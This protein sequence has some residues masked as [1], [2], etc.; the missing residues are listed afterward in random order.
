MIYARSSLNAI[1]VREWLPRIGHKG[2]TN[3]NVVITSLIEQ[4]DNV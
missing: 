3:A 1:M 4:V 2:K